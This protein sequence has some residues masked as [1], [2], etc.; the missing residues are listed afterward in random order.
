MRCTPIKY[1][2]MRHMPVRCTHEMHTHEMHAYEMHVR[3][4]Y[5]HEMHAHQ[6]HA[7]EVMPMKCMPKTHVSKSGGDT[8]ASKALR[9]KSANQRSWRVLP[10]ALPRGGPLLRSANAL[11]AE[12][13]KR[14]F[15]PI[16]HR[17]RRIQPQFPSFRMS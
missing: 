7:H 11:I 12:C 13:T 1:R 17:S 16:S 3:E 5:A 4:V 15:R 10:R 8:L 6:I 2:P 14:P 9:P